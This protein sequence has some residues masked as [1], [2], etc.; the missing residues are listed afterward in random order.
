MTDLRQLNR[1]LEQLREDIDY[2]TALVEPALRTP[3]LANP[4]PLAGTAPRASNAHVWHTLTRAEAADAWSTLCNWV[5]WLTDRYQLDDSLPDCWYR[6]AAMVD[7]LDALHVA[8]TGAYLDPSAR[9]TD[10]AYWHELLA[11]TLARVREWDRYGCAAGTHRDDIPSERSASSNARTAFVQHDLAARS[12]PRTKSEPLPRQPS[13]PRPGDGPG[14]LS[15]D[16][17]TI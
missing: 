13:D 8:W 5:D 1:D 16:V 17:T 11:R 7:E 3:D 12:R 9:P 6:H 2:L 4:A 15:G 10:A 14:D